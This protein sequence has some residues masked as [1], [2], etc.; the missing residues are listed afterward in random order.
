MGFLLSGWR[1]SFNG[2]RANTISEA[3]ATSVYH[4]LTSTKRRNSMHEAYKRKQGLHKHRSYDYDDD[5]FFRRHH[6]HSSQRSWSLHLRG[7]ADATATTATS[8]NP[9]TTTTTGSTLYSLRDTIENSGHEQ[10]EKDDDVASDDERVSSSAGLQTVNTRVIEPITT[11]IVIRERMNGS[12]SS[13]LS[14]NESIHT[15]FIPKT[16]T[17]IRIDRNGYKNKEVEEEEQDDEQQQQQQEEEEVQMLSTMEQ[18]PITPCTYIAE[19]NLPT[20]IG[21]FRLRA[22][23][24]NNELDFLKL[25]KNKFFGTEP[26]V[27]YSLDKSPL[28]IHEEGELKSELD[29]AIPVRIHDQCVTSEVFRSKRYV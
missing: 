5:L 14:T 13:F 16:S 23:R 7:G 11:S 10:H 2:T 22:Y 1:M 8:K 20:D 18:D 28:G 27:I 12:S 25:E 21:M 3:L 4:T 24:V 19:T 15:T 26:C 6:R 17:D 29:D 9:T